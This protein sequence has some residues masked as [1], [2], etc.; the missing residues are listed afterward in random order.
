M[1]KTKAKLFRRTSRMDR[2]WRR[3]ALQCRMLV[4]TKRLRWSRLRL[5]TVLEQS[6]K[7]KRMGMWLSW[8]HLRNKSKS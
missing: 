8:M 2:S 4:H 6:R 3:K 1:C 7:P 5:S